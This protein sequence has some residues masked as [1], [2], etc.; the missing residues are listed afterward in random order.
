MA[1]ICLAPVRLTTRLFVEA[2]QVEVESLKGTTDDGRL[3]NTTSYFL[4]F[5]GDRRSPAYRVSDT[6][7]GQLIGDTGPM[8]CM[9]YRNAHTPLRNHVRSPLT[10]VASSLMLFALLMMDLLQSV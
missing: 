3:V 7:E 10:L 6:L 1:G 4:A 5:I 2:H 8:C 9:L